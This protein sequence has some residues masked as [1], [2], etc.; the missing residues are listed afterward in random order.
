[1][2]KMR[3]NLSSES[4]RAQTAPGG[5]PIAK[6]KFYTSSY[7]EKRDKIFVAKS[8]PEKNHV[9]DPHAK[10]VRADSASRRQIS[11]TENLVDARH[12]CLN[13]VA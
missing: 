7:F 2:G 9:H 10:T 3:A 6:N 11:K 8:D 4:P 12:L 1:M 5:G 13:C